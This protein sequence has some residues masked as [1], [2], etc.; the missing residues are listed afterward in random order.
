MRLFAQQFDET[1]AVEGEFGRIEKG[2][3]RLL[4][5]G[6]HLR[7]EPGAGV[8]EGGEE[9]LDPVYPGAVGVVG[10]VLV[11]AE[12]GEGVDLFAEPFE[13]VE[14][15]DGVAEEGGGFSQAAAEGEKGFRQ[16]PDPVE[17]TLP[18]LRGGIEDLEVPGLFF[19]N[20]SE[21]LLFSTVDS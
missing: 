5:N 1:A 3:H 6:H 11:G 21:R 19:R 15:G 12:V 17:I 10:G 16:R 9:R 20:H 13:V 4:R 2:V 18:R 7:L 14:G 8:G